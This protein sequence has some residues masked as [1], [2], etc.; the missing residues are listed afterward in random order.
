VGTGSIPAIEGGASATVELEWTVIDLVSTPNWESC[1]LAR[2]GQ[3]GTGPDDITV[4]NTITDWI[5]QNNNI[6]MHNISVIDMFGPEV[7]EL[8]DRPYPGGWVY[9][10][11]NSGASEDFD[12][13]LI[14]NDTKKD[15][16]HNEAEIVLHFEETGFDISGAINDTN[17]VGLTRVDSTLF[18]VTSGNARIRHINIPK[19]TLIPVFVGYGFLTGS[20]SDTL[21]YRYHLGQYVSSKPDT[22]LSGQHFWIDR[23]SRNLFSADAGSDVTILAG[24]TITLSAADIGEDA[25]FFWSN[26]SGTQIGTGDEVDV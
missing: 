15:G 25:L 11:N 14:L 5:W 16:L 26:G 1:L 6:A 12:V 23:V 24:D 22:L 4:Q 9:V 8:N 7:V 17:L 2:I 3:E 19:D 10:G 18:R 20:V 13:Q 21:K